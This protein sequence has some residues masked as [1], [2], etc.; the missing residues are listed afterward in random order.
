MTAAAKAQTNNINMDGGKF[1]LRKY[2]KNK[3]S[4]RDPFGSAY[5]SSRKGAFI[6]NNHHTTR[7]IK[8]IFKY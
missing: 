2:A 6:V 3:K 1:C 5:M 4:G 8:L 7:N